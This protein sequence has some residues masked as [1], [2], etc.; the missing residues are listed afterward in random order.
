MKIDRIYSM[1]S[2]EKYFSSDGSL[3]FFFNCRF[4]VDVKTGENSI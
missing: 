4:G 2:C 1:N 3:Q